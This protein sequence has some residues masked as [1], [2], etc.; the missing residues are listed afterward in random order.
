MKNGFT[1]IELVVSAGIM[2]VLSVTLVSVLAN[3][4]QASNRITAVA[5]VEQQGSWVIG[6]LK[7]VVPLAQSNSLTCTPGVDMPFLDMKNVLDGLDTTII[8]NEDVQKIASRSAS[9]AE[10]ID[11]VN[12]L[13]I[14]CPKFATCEGEVGGKVNAVKFSFTLSKQAVG[15][16]ISREFNTRILLRN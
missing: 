6:Q 11:W 16:T 15:Q 9:R 7:Q 14:N 12:G 2:A 5:E 4:Y 1:M 10:D 13:V 8:C 3:T